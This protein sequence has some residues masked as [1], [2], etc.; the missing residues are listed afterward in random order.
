MRTD[1]ERLQQEHQTEIRS[2]RES[3]S[4]ELES[5]RQTLQAEIRSAQTQQREA[6]KAAEESQRKLEDAERCYCVKV[7]QLNLRLAFIGIQYNREKCASQFYCAHA[8]RTLGASDVCI[9]IIGKYGSTSYIG[10]TR[11]KNGSQ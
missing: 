9:D 5:T 3:S 2:L 8:S 10:M 1:A 11:E 6:E 4:A 7:E